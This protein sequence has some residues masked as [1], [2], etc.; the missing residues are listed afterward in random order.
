LISIKKYLDRDDPA[1]TVAEPEPD[2]LL[3]V[4]M[5]SYR[6]ALRAIGS[7]A[8]KACPAPGRELQQGLTALESSL[9][10][11]VTA[12]AVKLTQDEAEERLARWGSATA[13]YLKDQAD[14]VKELLLLLAGTAES[15]GERDQRYAEQ[16]SGLTAD[17]KSI[18]NLHDLTQVRSSLVRK[19][20]ELKS[21]VDQMAQDGQQSI[22]QLRSKVTSYETKLK[23]VEEIA[24]KDTVTGLANRRSVES[25]M[26]RLIA[27]HET[28]CAVILDLNRFKQI[29]DKFGHPAGDDLLKKFAHELQNNV[30]SD[31]MV[32]RWGGDEFIVILRRDVAGAKPQVDRIRQWVFGNYTLETGAGKPTLKVDVIASIGLAQWSPGMTIKQVIE[33]ADAAMYRDKRESQS[34]SGKS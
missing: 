21:C 26:E 27:Q 28:F 25:R 29:N 8:V 20:A 22:A 10:A 15:V 30:R 12:K 32:G 19:A 6:A 14:E 13:E 24:S 17:L 3:A 7:N 4:T 5:E 31:D 16:F 11:G 9:S 34:R 2:E 1:V 18:A 33:Q 23:A